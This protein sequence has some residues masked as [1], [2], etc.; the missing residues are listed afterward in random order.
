MLR[1]ELAEAQEPARLPCNAGGDDYYPP[2]FKNKRDG[3]SFN[4]YQRPG[5]TEQ[6]FL[7]NGFEE[8][9]ELNWDVYDYQARYYDAAL[10]R[11]LNVD[12]AADLMRRHS[13][14]NYAFDN[15][16]SFIDP[17]GMIP[18][19]I[20]P[21]DPSSDSNINFDDDLFNNSKAPI[22]NDKGIDKFGDGNSNDGFIRRDG[23]NYIAGTGEIKG[24]TKGNG[25]GDGSKKKKNRAGEF[26]AGTLAAAV[27]TSKL[28]TPFPS[29]ADLVAGAEIIVGGLVALG[30][31]IYDAANDNDPVIT[32]TPAPKDLPGFPG[33]TRAKP[34]GGRTR[35]KTPEGDILEWD[36]QHGD[37]EVY[38][39][40]GK[41]KGTADPE[42]GEM[43]KEP[44]PGRTIDP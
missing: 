27:I 9:S 34:K 41:H 6:K 17:D 40:R 1:A 11:F 22:D 35:W 5:E 16:I 30:I 15:P 36:S 7:Y 4:S 20:K 24:K 33:A 18:F 37:V 2:A 14:Y 19:D 38:N 3:L 39:K 42:T 32:Y 29:P 21:E 26:M 44:V 43:I 31:L 25:P 10:G 12:P 13:P 8:Q 28:D 23:P